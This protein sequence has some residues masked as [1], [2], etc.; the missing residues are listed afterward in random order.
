MKKVIILYNFKGSAELEWLLPILFELKKNF[1][2]FTV[3]KNKSAFNSLKNNNKN[4]IA[5]KKISNHFLF[6]M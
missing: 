6:F 5:W 2:I 4:Y 1:F 3:F